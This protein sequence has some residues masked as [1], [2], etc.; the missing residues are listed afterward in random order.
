MNSKDT[1][2]IRSDPGNNYIR[3][4]IFAHEQLQA[5]SFHPE[6]AYNHIEF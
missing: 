3:A 5:Y 2:K 4:N 1:L 6:N